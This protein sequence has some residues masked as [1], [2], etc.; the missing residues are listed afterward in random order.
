[1]SSLAPIWPMEAVAPR[2]PRAVSTARAFRRAPSFL[3]A[4]GWPRSVWAAAILARIF[5]SQGRGAAA[6]DLLRRCL[7]AMNVH[8]GVAELL[9]EDGRWNL[10]YFAT[11]HGALCSA[12]HAL[13]LRNDDAGLRPFP[14]LPPSWRDVA[15]ERLL[16]DGYEVS[17][18]R[19][20][21]RLSRL[22]LTNRADRTRTGLVRPGRGAHRV[23]LEPGQTWSWRATASEPRP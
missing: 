13:L 22:E 18:T 11:A 23:T 4:G 14:A 21:G 20:D 7:P 15:F 9:G 1:M 12:I 8:G 6:F 2:D 10:Q 3:T 5:A 19:E 17:A 16:I